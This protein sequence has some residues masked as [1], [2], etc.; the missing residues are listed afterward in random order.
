[1]SKAEDILKLYSQ[2]K[3]VDNTKNTQNILDAVKQY[4]DSKGDNTPSSNPPQKVNTNVE[5]KEVPPGYEEALSR[6]KQYQTIL[7]PALLN[8]YPEAKNVYD[9]I[10][11]QGVERYKTYKEKLPDFYLTEDEQKALLKDKYEQYQKDM[12]L[13]YSHMN[14]EY[15]GSMEVRGTEEGSDNPL[16][17]GLRTASLFQY[18][19]KPREVGSEEEVKKAGQV[20]NIPKK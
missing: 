5:T 20:L 6:V 14:K 9:A 3:T 7:T 11:K 10:T 17:Y 12:D 8:K 15:P 19:G 13:V 16:L 18:T 1:M 2:L 4:D